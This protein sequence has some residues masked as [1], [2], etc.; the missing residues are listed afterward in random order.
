VE[1]L[2]CAQHRNVVMLIGYCIEGKRRLLVYEFICNGSLDSHL[3]EKERTPLEWASR[4]KIAIGA[5]R[6]LRYL[7]EECRVGCIVHRD[8]RPNNILLTHDFEPMVGDFGLARWQ[9]DGHCGVETRVIGT[10]GYLAPEYT[11]HGQITDKAD[12]YSF[13]VVLLELITGRK[14]IDINRPKGEQCLT[15]WARPLLEERGTLPVDP[16]LEN[17]FSDIEVDCMLHAAACCIRRDPLQRP[18]MSQVLRMLEGEMI[19]DANGSP[20]S[21]YFAGRL[22]NYP[23]YHLMMGPTVREEVKYPNFVSPQSDYHSSHCSPNSTLSNL[24]Y[25]PMM[26]S[27]TMNLSPTS[28]EFNKKLTM[29]PAYVNHDG[30]KLSYEALRAAYMDKVSSNNNNVSASAY[31]SYQLGKDF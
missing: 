22:N 30:V 10:F 7:H 15:E 31:E 9:P 1:V 27:P 5:A 2:S 6:G 14:A 4:H 23:A 13:G 12:V 25:G 17:R 18:R 16:R 21:A 29:V 19:F 11:Q 20:T 26:S 8:L 24:P 3:Y 28:R